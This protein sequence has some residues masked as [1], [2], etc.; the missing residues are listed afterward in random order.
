MRFE[1]QSEFK[2]NRFEITSVMDVFNSKL[3]ALRLVKWKIELKRSPVMEH[4]SKRRK[5]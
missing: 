5:I 2:Y 1:K 4:K 3:N